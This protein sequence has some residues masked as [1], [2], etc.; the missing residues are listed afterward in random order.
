MRYAATT[1]YG[2]PRATH[3]PIAGQASP[4]SAAARTARKPHVGLRIHDRRWIQPGRSDSG[5]SA[6]VTSQ[7][8]NSSMFASALA[9]R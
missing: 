7:T 1:A 3:M 9:L 5:T 4:P 8:G 6:P 2:R